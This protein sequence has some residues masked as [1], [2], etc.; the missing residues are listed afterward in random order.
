MSDGNRYEEE[1]I[2]YLQI[3][4]SKIIEILQSKRSEILIKRLKNNISSFHDFW[5][6]IRDFFVDEIGRDRELNKELIR[7]KKAGHILEKEIGKKGIFDKETVLAGMNTFIIIYIASFFI[8]KGL[9]KKGFKLSN[10]FFI[11]LPYFSSKN[12][13]INK[14]IL[15]INPKYTVFRTLDKVEFLLD[16]PLVKETFLK[17]GGGACP[18][19]SSTEN[20]NGKKLNADLSRTMIFFLDDVYR[21]VL[22]KY[23][24]AYKNSSINQT[25]DFVNVLLGRFEINEEH[26]L[27]LEKFIERYEKP[28][29]K[30]WFRKFF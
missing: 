10:F 27:S 23:E 18:F 22:I 2:D 19:T 14:R 17:M 6:I 25:P 13:T 1:D 4:V 16:I 26:L 5:E 8:S 29:K 20:T 24:E 3:I 28:Q 9:E 21:F 30:S 7:R 11:I 12:Q 15:G